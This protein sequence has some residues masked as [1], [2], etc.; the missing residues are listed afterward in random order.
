MGHTGNGG[1]V[2]GESDVQDNDRTDDDIKAMTDELYDEMNGMVSWTV[3]EQTLVALFASFEE[4]P[5]QL[6]VPILVRRQAKDLLCELAAEASE[7]NIAGQS[8]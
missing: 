4:A 2:I 5:V 8:G 3:V 1:A 7:T 6:Y